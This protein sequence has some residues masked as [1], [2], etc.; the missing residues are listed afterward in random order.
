MYLMNDL[1]MGEK[2]ITFYSVVAAWVPHPPLQKSIHGQ[3]SGVTDEPAELLV[4]R[5]TFKSI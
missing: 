1:P 3:S 2:S 5:R 4:R